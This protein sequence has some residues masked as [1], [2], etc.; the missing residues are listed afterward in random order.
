MKVMYVYTKGFPS[1]LSGKE[2]VYNAGDAGL[3]PGLGRSPRGGHDNSLQ[4]FCLDNP[5]NKGAWQAAAH[6]VAKSQT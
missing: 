5:M 4:Y 6:R 3:I 2:S 1:W